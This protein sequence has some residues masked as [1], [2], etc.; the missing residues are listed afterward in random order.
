M[1]PNRQLAL[2]VGLCF[3]AL[4]G[5]VATAC[6]SAN[7][8]APSGTFLSLTASP[9]NIGLNGAATITVI[10]RRPDGSPLFEGTEIVLST[11]L[12]SLDQTVIQVG[13]AGSAQ[14]TLR[15]AGRSGTATVTATAGAGTGGGEGGG[16][17]MATTEVEIGVVE[18]GRTL[19]VSA[20]PTQISLGGTSQITIVV[21]RADDTS[22]PAGTEVR[23]TTTLGSLPAVVN[24]NSDGIATA[25]LRASGQPGTA[26]VTAST[27]SGENSAS[28]E[29]TVTIGETDETKP[30][31]EVTANPSIIN[32]Q[33]TSQITVVGRQAD[34]SPVG[35]GEQ[36]VLTS[37]LGTLT[38]RTVTTGSDG[39]ATSTLVAEDQAGEATIT[40]F[41]GA[42]DPATTTVTI[43][44]TATSLSLG[45]NK[46]SV[47]RNGDTLTLTAVATNA[48]GQ[49]IGN[50]PIT[51]DPE[52]GTLSS[53]VVQTNA[54]GIAETTLT[55]DEN[56]IPNNRNSFSVDAS[57]PDND[58]EPVEAETKTI[59]VT[60]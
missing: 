27:G 28:G 10:G 59:N 6:D 26:T 7:P 2:T 44:D 51:F 20:D 22:P 49:T 56:D 11:S 48:Q 17:T 4:A 24:T 25:T 9:N 8:V 19:T 5:L 38:P 45:S 36:V 21:R 32:I 23:L 58:G 3:V 41:L 50:I 33:E 35:A 47:S 40:A 39:V 54:Q 30:T 14:T 60:N 16:V 1:T 12:G 15:G 53:T 52:F 31:V 43:R 42:S 46:S 55:I 18:S 57:A 29:A 37:N 34:G 13:E